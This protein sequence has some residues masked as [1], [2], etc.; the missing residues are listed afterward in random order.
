MCWVG[1]NWRRNLGAEPAA[2]PGGARACRQAAQACR[3]KRASSPFCPCPYSFPKKEKGMLRLMG[4]EPS[5]SACDRRLVRPAEPLRQ[6][7]LATEVMVMGLTGG[8]ARVC[9]CATWRR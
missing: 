8:E 9:C 1:G 2:L 5:S 4:T 3:H 7:L 6:L